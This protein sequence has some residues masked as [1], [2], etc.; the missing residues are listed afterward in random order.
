MLVGKAKEGGLQKS[1]LLSAC[2]SVLL[3][4]NSFAAEEPHLYNSVFTYGAIVDV[5][6]KFCESACVFFNEKTKTEEGFC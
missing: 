4:H 1:H 5:D 3:P 6:T 2:A